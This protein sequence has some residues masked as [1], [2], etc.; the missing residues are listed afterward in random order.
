MGAGWFLARLPVIGGLLTVIGF[1][2]NWF[3]S[4]GSSGIDR[5]S[6]GANA[7]GYVLSN[8]L[9]G[10]PADELF[11][12][13]ILP[14]LTVLALIAGIFGLLSFLARKGLRLPTT[15]LAVLGLIVVVAYMLVG[16][17]TTGVDMGTV[18][19]AWSVGYYLLLAG[20]L[21]MAITPWFGKSK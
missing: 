1:V 9:D 17:Y 4:P 21:W 6:E 19:S 14:L 3:G 2:L 20:L 8:G 12:Y 16:S 10:I 13:M 5:V 7:L 11:F 18:A 15:I